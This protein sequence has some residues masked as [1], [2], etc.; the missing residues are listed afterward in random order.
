EGDFLLAVD[1]TTGGTLGGTTLYQWH[2][3]KDP[4]TQPADG[5]VCNPGKKSAAHYQQI[6]STAIKINVNGGGDIGCGGW[7]CRN[8]DGSPNTTLL[9]NE[10]MEGGID[11]AQLGFTGC[12]STF[13][14]HTRSSQSF[15]AVLKDFEIIPFNT[16]RHPTVT[17]TI[18]PA[19]PTG[20]ASIPAT[21]HDTAQINGGTADAGGHISYKLYDNST[22]TGTDAATGLLAD[23][24]PTVD[25]VVNGVA[26]D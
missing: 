26:P 1:F 19:Q 10:L 6:G 25:T 7:V 15:T 23:L 5:T 13:L 11:L 18:V 16:C 9:T 12:I 2:C 4:G 17:T 8:P 24:T 14:P 3:A 20:G 21:A 22:C